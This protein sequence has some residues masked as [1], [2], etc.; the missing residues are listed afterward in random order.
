MKKLCIIVCLVLF[1][2]YLYINIKSDIQSQNTHITTGTKR[3]KNF[4]LD[5]VLQSRY[6]DIHYNAYIPKAYD[7][8]QSYALYITLPGYQGLYFQ[9]VGENLKTEE[10]AFTS[11]KYKDHMIILAP[12][13]EDWGELSANKTVALTKY[14][15]KH[16]AINPKQVYISGY[17]GGGETLSL[18]LSKNP[19]LY[20]RALMCSS[21]WDGDFNKVVENKTPIYFVI[22]EDDEYYG[23]SSFKEAYQELVNLYKQQ[24][25]SDEEIKNYVV[26]DVKNN[27]YFLTQGIVNQHG[28]GGHLFSNDQQIMGWL[29]Y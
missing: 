1:S 21:K 29:F 27:D 19:E 24:G 26:L 18:V 10:F 4:S 17:S 25:L 7:K 6:G 22:G 12:Q 13:L 15:L 9:G 2:T 14:F 23:S 8:R 20:R 5:N 28:Q 16:Y 3:Y 11:Q